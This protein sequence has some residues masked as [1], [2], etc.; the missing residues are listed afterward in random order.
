MKNLGK[1]IN[2]LIENNL[3]DSNRLNEL[4]DRIKSG[5]QLYN[6]DINY[7]EK[8]SPTSELKIEKSKSIKKQKLTNSKPPVSDSTPIPILNN[9][10][11]TSRNIPDTCKPYA[12]TY[13]TSYRDEVKI[14]AN[15]CH[16]T[17]NASQSGST[18]WTYANSLKDAVSVARKL[19]PKYGNWKF[20][21]CCLYTGASYF[22]CK[23]CK[24]YSE[25]YDNT[26]KLHSRRWRLTGIFFVII[27]FLVILTGIQPHLKG[28]NILLMFIGMILLGVENSRAP[29]VCRNC[30]SKDWGYWGSEN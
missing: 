6:S 18:K 4:L 10:Q 3:G 24:R 28:L 27:P 20:P 16:H 11:T 14:H 29:K 15:T 21:R 13:N 25:G 12:I 17:Q 22:Q 26:E 5:K 30:L 9:K 1:K 19:Y 8:L 23:D 2:F 7:V